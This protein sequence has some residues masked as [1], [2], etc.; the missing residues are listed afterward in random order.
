MQNTKYKTLVNVYVNFIKRENA[1]R[2][3]RAVAS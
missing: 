3:N 1:S 2:P